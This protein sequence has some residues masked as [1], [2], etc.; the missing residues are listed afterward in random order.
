MPAPLGT[1]QDVTRGLSLLA[2]STSSF[3]ESHPRMGPFLCPWGAR[4]AADR[5]VQSTGRGQSLQRSLAAGSCLAAGP[6]G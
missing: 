1:T 2:L 6:G 4:K 3:L 5:L